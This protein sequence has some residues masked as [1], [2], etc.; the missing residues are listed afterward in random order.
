MRLA[1]SP[2][3]IASGGML[4]GCYVGRR[5]TFVFVV[6][7]AH[8]V[9]EVDRHAVPLARHRLS[10]APNL[11]RAGTRHAHHYGAVRRERHA[12]DPTA[13]DG[14]PVD[15]LA[16][17]GVATAVGLESDGATA[18]HATGRLRLEGQHLV[19]GDREDGVALLVGR[20]SGAAWAGGDQVALAGSDVDGKRQPTHVAGTG[21]REGH[22]CA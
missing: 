1:V 15:G 4:D 19:A 20:V 11:A 8:S 6:R 16:G 22:R 7:S 13:V 10:V 3:S 2:T 21:I 9:G 17:A 12:A 5:P 14:P 18:V